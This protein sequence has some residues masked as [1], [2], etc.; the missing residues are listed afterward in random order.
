MKMAEQWIALSTIVRKEI[1]RFTRIWVQTLLPP[2]ITMGLYFVIFGQLIGSRIGQMDGFSYVEFVVPGLIMMSVITNSYSNV[3][4]SFFGVKFQKSVE[5]LLVSP[6]PNYIILLGYVLGGVSRGLL[7]GFIVTLVSSFFTDL[8]IHSLP[9]TIAIVF[10]T[11]VVFSLAGFFNAVFAR[12]FDD[13]SIVPTFILTPL[14]YLGGVFYSISLLPPFWQSVS[15]LNPILY[16][17]NA[18]RY[19]ILGISDI[20]INYAFFGVLVFII[21][22]TVIC[23]RLLARGTRLRS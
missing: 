7:V 11:A 2:V 5:E 23:L 9:I 21:L 10:M 13:I 20:N 17:V 18:F 12:T 8:T 3:V 14:T 6:T 19:G 22:L 16:M 1:V 15:Q 4:S